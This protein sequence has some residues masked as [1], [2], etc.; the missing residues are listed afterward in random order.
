MTRRRV[1]GKSKGIVR[2]P[3]FILAESKYPALWYQRALAF[4]AGE[5]A[6]GNL[7]SM[8]ARGKL[9]EPIPEYLA[10]AKDGAKKTASTP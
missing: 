8:Q 5:T 10:R 6:D 9:G 2:R 4:S 7:A 3:E 1:P